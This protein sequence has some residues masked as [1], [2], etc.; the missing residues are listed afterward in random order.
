MV[1]SSQ[2]PVFGSRK[3]Q[4]SIEFTIMAFFS[5]MLLLAATF[6]YSWQSAEIAE[7]RTFSEMRSICSSLSAR[8]SGLVMAGSGASVKLDYP[9]KLY[10]DNY[11]IW[12]QGNESIV[13]VIRTDALGEVSSVGCYLK[14]RGVSN[15][16]SYAFFAGANDTLRN[17]EGVVVFGR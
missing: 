14:T 9:E 17:D 11:S 2:L 15:G 13:K 1:F 12:V 4:A 5:L 10:G 16:T 7:A 8:V 6:I 3:A